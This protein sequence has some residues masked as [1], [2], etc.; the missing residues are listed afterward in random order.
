[1]DF[2]AFGRFIF[3][4]PFL[5]SMVAAALF[6]LWLFFKGGMLHEKDRQNFEQ[7]AIFIMTEFMARDAADPK[8]KKKKKKKPPYPVT[9]GELVDEE[10]WLYSQEPPAPPSAANPPSFTHLMF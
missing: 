2:E 10:M 5:F 8:P 4:Q 1:M 3:E 9:D 6:V 7:D